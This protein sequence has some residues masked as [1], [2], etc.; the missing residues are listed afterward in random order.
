[1]FARIF[2]MYNRKRTS[3]KKIATRRYAPTPNATDFDTIL[4]PPLHC[5]FWGGLSSVSMDNYHHGMMVR[6]GNFLVDWAGVLAS[7]QDASV[8]RIASTRDPLDRD[9]GQRILGAEEINN[10]IRFWQSQVE[11]GNAMVREVGQ[12]LRPFMRQELEDHKT[13]RL[14]HSST[15][16]PRSGRRKKDAQIARTQPP[17]AAYQEEANPKQFRAVDT[18]QADAQITRTLLGISNPPVGRVY[19]V[20]CFLIDKT[21]APGWFGGVKSQWSRGTKHVE[22]FFPGYFGTTSATYTILD[23]ERGSRMV[24]GKLFSRNGYTHICIPV[25]RD[26][27]MRA[28]DEADRRRGLE[29]LKD[30]QTRIAEDFFSRVVGALIP[31]GACSSHKAHLSNI[32]GVR[33]DSTTTSALTCSKYVYF[34]LRAVG[35]VEINK[36]LDAFNPDAVMPSDL[37]HILAHY[38]GHIVKVKIDFA[39]QHD[40]GTAQAI[41]K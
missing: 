36:K 7:A 1:M 21:P 14:S 37:Y 28:R 32:D 15:P 33:Q 8:A 34:I 30:Y 16:E 18:T 3:S 25:T 24:E 5:F 35:N 9:P 19:I 27:F 17:A 38:E 2:V 6:Y 26:E 23:D 39:K 12:I 41:V 10:H 29:Y 11:H 40:T 13:T 4:L 31:F 22:T 20:F